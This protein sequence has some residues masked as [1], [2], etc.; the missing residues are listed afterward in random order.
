[1][2][3][4]MEKVHWKK[5]VCLLLCS[6]LCVECETPFSFSPFEAKVPIEL[7]NTTEKNLERVMARDT[8]QN[9]SFNV[10]LLSDVHYHFNELRNALE[11][12][13]ARNDIAF[14]V[15]TGDITDN[16]LQKEFELFRNIMAG[17]KVPWLTVIGNHDYL[18]N[19]R[20]VYRQMFGELNYSFVFN[21]TKLVFWDNVKWES[22]Q[23]PDWEWFM[24]TVSETTTDS[25]IQK[26]YDQ[27]IP[28]SH[29]PPIDGQFIR[30]AA[31]QHELFRTQGIKLSVHGHKHEFSDEEYYGDGVRYVTIGSPQKKNYAV[32]QVRPQGSR[33]VKVNY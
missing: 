23:A 12:I 24:T 10:A 33:V 19:G 13:N 4:K 14:I 11:D 1:M 15:V 22:N 29:I 18:S 25:G 16:G 2:M 8:L 30:H 31:G 17:S 26:E 9:G 27:V 28:F 5:L 7:R 32:L 6:Y 20:D 21:R 3:G